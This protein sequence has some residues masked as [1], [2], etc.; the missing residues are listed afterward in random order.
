MK[1]KTILCA[2]GLSLAPTL[3]LAAGCSGMKPAETASMSCADG[4]VFDAATNSCV[5][6]VTS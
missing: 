6:Q 4:Q 3:S 5:D 1:T 2:L